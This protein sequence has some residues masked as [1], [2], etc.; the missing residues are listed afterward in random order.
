VVMY[1]L[2][3]L[4]LLVMFLFGDA[5]IELALARQDAVDCSAFASYEEANA[6]LAAN[7]DAAPA[8]DDDGDGTACE[9][10][11]GL[12]RRNRRNQAEEGD[13]E[14]AQEAAEDLDCE[15]F[16]T[17]EE[18]QA[19]L[20]ADPADPNNLD[21]NGDGIACALLPSAADA[22]PAPEQEQEQPAEEETDQG[23]QERRNER[24]NRRNQDE[25]SALTCDDFATQEEAQA[26]F[27][28]D[29]EGLIALDE[30]GNLIACEELPPAEDNQERRRNRRNQE[31]PTPEPTVVDE[32]RVVDIDC[33]D[34]EFQEEAQLVYDQDPSDPYNLDPNGDGFACSSLPIS[35]ASVQQVPRTGAGVAVHPFAALAAAALVI[36]LGAAAFGFRRPLRK[37]V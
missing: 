23:N 26:A 19:A 4:S 6:Y 2:M 5:S 20:E 24:R 35:G 17:Q 14:L 30:D 25:P 15:D 10:F 9:V 7:P 32:P 12:E 16:L 13:A 29:P 18:A 11:F 28:E 27:D 22:V 3:S 36:G 37:E 1:R 31:E 34:F 21:P 33:V 8:L